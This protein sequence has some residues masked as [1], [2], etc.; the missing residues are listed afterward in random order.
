MGWTIEE[1][2]FSFWYGQEIFV[3]LKALRLAL[4]YTQPP[5]QW[6]LICVCEISLGVKQPEHKG[7]Q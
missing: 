6:V 3:S 4:G 7:D 2:W 5:I 1:S